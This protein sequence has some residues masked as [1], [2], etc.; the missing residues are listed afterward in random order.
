M[1]R[2]R[3]SPGRAR[4]RPVAGF[5]F[6]QLVG[7][8]DDLTACVGTP[9]Y[10]APEVV[11][12]GVF[13]DGAPYGRAVDLWALGVL[14]FVVLTGGPPFL[15]PDR[16][17]LFDSIAAGQWA[18]PKTCALSQL[19]RDL[20]RGLL[21]VDPNA[22]LTA[23]A[24]LRHPFIAHG[25]LHSATRC[26]AAGAGG[27]A[28]RD[29][30][31]RRFWARH[32]RA[33]PHCVWARAGAGADRRGAGAGA[34][35]S[36]GAQR[37]GALCPRPSA[38]YAPHSSGPR[39]SCQPRGTL[40]APY[41]CPAPCSTPRPSSH[42]LAPIVRAPSP[43]P[44][45]PCAPS[46][47]PPASRSEAPAAS[48]SADAPPPRAPVPALCPRIVVQTVP[49]DGG[50]CADDPTDPSV[51]V[52]SQRALVS[53]ASSQAS[54]PGSSPGPSPP[55]SP[56]ADSAGEGR[57]ADRHPPIAWAL[58]GRKAPA[59]RSATAPA[60]DVPTTRGTCVQTP[61]P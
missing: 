43:L 46:V 54:T 44:A 9:Y 2:M 32:R 37:Y 22:R 23:R 21:V 58:C 26:P 39:P 61:A 10:M 38:A 56:R 25:A 28:A 33:V 5:R 13:G 40:P 18:F 55:P 11:R 6:A 27:P 50:P 51:L 57:P 3:T 42:A 45:P 17:A 20:L 48:G 15:G 47:P 34:A 1:R 52:I 19:G 35:P 14:G 7:D 8:R 29:A 4:A 59:H 60:A 53:P 36:T 41:R 31:L 16:V 12:R 49:S 30:A 24:A